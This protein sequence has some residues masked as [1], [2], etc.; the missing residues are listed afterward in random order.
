M[1]K[2]MIKNTSLIIIRYNKKKSLISNFM[3]KER[4]GEL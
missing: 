1:M 4:K 3:R 2:V